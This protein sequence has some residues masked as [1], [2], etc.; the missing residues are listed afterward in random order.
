MNYTKEEILKEINGLTNAAANSGTENDS[1]D[2]SVF[3]SKGIAIQQDIIELHARKDYKALYEDLLKRLASSSFAKKFE[4]FMRNAART[5]DKATDK[6][7]RFVEDNVDRV[8]DIEIPTTKTI[9]S[10]LSSVRDSVLGGID[11]I[12]GKAVIDKRMEETL[13][14]PKRPE[15]IERDTWLYD[16]HGRNSEI[17]SDETGCPVK[18]CDCGHGM[19]L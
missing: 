12:T 13:A 6:A 10:S 8:G 18:D 19:D 5:T 1:V 3:I 2:V 16:H 15:D 14:R 4:D 17:E 9:M 11:K 7:F